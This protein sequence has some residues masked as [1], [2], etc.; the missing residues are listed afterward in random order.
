MEKKQK[1]KKHRTSF[2]KTFMM[3]DVP[4]Q[5]VC[6][7]F[8]SEFLATKAMPGMKYVSSEDMQQ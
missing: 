4:F 1:T 2:P 5:S 8:L 7:I 3:C 6:I